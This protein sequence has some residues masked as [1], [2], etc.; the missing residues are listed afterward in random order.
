M[1]MEYSNE[2]VCLYNVYY[3]LVNGG[4]FSVFSGTFLSQRIF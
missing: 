3:V 2:A 1:L 4:P